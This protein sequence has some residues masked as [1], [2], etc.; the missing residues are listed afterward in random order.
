[1]NKPQWHPPRIVTAE[2]VGPFGA[3]TLLAL[4]DGRTVVV[5]N[6]PT[7][8]NSTDAERKARKTKQASLA[9]Q[10]RRARKKKR[11]PVT[12]RI[13][14]V[15]MF[16]ALLPYS[17]YKEIDAAA[18]KRL[19]HNPRDADGKPISFEEARALVIADM[20]R[21]EVKKGK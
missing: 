15:S 14:P 10:V 20:V 21:A 19:E 9:T 12:K 8:V 11:N 17:T 3:F 6:T 7:V 18:F 16:K 2:A 1:M 4:V 5:P 13:D